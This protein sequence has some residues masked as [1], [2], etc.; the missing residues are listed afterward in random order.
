MKTGKHS[1][2]YY[3]VFPEVHCAERHIHN[4]R[5]TVFSAVLIHQHFMS[6]LWRGLKVSTFVLF[7]LYYNKENCPRPAIKAL[8]D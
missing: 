7:I 2:R 4:N 3:F 5:P 8:P 1:R 6:I